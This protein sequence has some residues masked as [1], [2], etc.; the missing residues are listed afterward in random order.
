MNK[1]LNWNL[2]Y[3]QTNERGG[4]QECGYRAATIIQCYQNKNIKYEKDPEP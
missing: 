4:F 1:Y 2:N 3:K